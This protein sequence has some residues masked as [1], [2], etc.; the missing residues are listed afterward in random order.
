[1]ADDIGAEGLASY[2]STIYTT[3][4]PDRRAAEAGLDPPA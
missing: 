4:N 1:M 3:P 2:G